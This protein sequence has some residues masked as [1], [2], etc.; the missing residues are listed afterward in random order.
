MGTFSYSF[1]QLTV[2]IFLLLAFAI[3][4]N[5]KE[6]AGGHGGE[7]VYC[8]GKEAVVLDYFHAAK[9][10]F[11]S[12]APKLI[13]VESM[14]T[15]EVVDSIKDKL[16]KYIFSNFR[17]KWSLDLIGD[18]N[19]W[20]EADLSQVNDANSAY[21]IPGCTKRTVAKRQGDTMYIDPSVAKDLSPGQLGILIW[22]EVLY[23][24]SGMDTSEKVRDAMRIL[25]NAEIS[26]EDFTKL[27]SPF[28]NY[29]VSLSG[30][31]LLGEIKGL[32]YLE[33][34]YKMV[35]PNLSNCEIEFTAPDLE[36]NQASV[37]PLPACFF[38]DGKPQA[39]VI[40]CDHKNLVNTCSV[41]ESTPEKKFL[42]FLTMERESEGR[43]DYA[44]FLTFGNNN[45]SMRFER[46]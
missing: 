19:A 41:Y 28:M 23:H 11:G 24:L 35:K 18:I 33:G 27:P 30:E 31:G 26:R 34:K 37:L 3:D 43:V 7:V 44:R 17:L 10:N 25:L 8:P 9:K 42:Y 21:E 14:S 20:I 2:V 32:P 13:S 29:P 5:A 4:S 39:R 45:F 15:Q 36:K 12:P 40:I 16:K 1:R 6:G 46:E 22:H 38:A